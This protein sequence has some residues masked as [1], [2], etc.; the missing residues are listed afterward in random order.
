MT[1]SRQTADW[2]SRAGLAKIVPSS[3]A[4]GSGTGSASSLGT[5]TFSGASSVS[6]NGVFSSTYNNYLIQMNNVTGN[7]GFV[8]LRLRTSTDESGAQYFTQELAGIGSSAVAART[9]SGTSWLACF[10]I[11]SAYQNLG[12]MVIYNP[13]NTV[14]TT[15]ESSL[16]TAANGSGIDFTYFG[17]GLNTTTSYTGFTV[18]ASANN[19]T[20]S[21]SVYGYN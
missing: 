2:G 4:V 3:V 20:G 9:S 19:I 11:E 21:L 12:S 13:F 1:R 14:V 15:A 16:T 6:L 17:R 8:G 10:R 5:V 7:A 18:I